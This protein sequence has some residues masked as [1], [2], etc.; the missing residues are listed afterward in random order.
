MPVRIKPIHDL[1][2]CSLDLVSIKGICEL[3]D[4]NFNTALYSA[5]DGMWEVYNETTRSFL[6]AISLLDNSSGMPKHETLDSFVIDAKNQV[7][8]KVGKEKIKK[9]EREIEIVFDK[10]QATI[11]FSG[12]YEMESWF[13]HFVA[14]LKKH[15]RQPTFLQRLTTEPGVRDIKPLPYTVMLSSLS[16][17]ASSIMSKSLG[18]SVKISNAPYC[19]IILYRKSPN[20]LVENVKA[21]LIANFLWVPIVFV[22]GILFALLAYW[23]WSRY[24]LNIYKW[25]T[26]PVIPAIT[27]IP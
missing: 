18:V 9:I 10:N 22:F 19:T 25:V 24:N 5:E 14:D 17:I 20:A 13:E 16:S 15:L 3:V 7:E 6:D 23:I 1:K 11:R 2:P 4:R 12:P 8:T 27:P 21:G 26:P